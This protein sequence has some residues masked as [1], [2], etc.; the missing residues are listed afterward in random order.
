M[1]TLRE[2]QLDNGLHIVFTD[3]SNRYFG[4]YHRICIVASIHCHLDD[5]STANDEEAAL[6]DRAKRKFG[7][8]L[9]ITKRFERMGVPSK[10]TMVPSPLSLVKAELNKKPVP[11]FYA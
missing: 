2:A 7:N 6:I 4:D 8:T 11:R 5:L 10:S 9:T 3:E 1:T